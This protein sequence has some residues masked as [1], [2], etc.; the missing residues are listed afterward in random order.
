VKNI[1][2]TIRILCGSLIALSVWALWMGGGP[3][4]LISL[5]Y[6]IGTWV[7]AETKMHMMGSEE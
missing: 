5:T 4:I 6:A 7:M 1:K 2:A 3:C